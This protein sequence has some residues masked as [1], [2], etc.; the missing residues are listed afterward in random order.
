MAGW[1][2][3]AWVSLCGHEALAQGAVG[4]Y[5]LE[6]IAKIGAPVP[7][8]RSALGQD[9]IDLSTGNPGET[10]LFAKNTLVSG[11]G[12]VVYN[13]SRSLDDDPSSA[14]SAIFAISAAAGPPISQRI[15]LPAERS[16]MG[17]GL[18]FTWPTIPDYEISVFRTATGWSISEANSRRRLCG[19]I[20]PSKG[21]DAR[22]VSR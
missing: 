4:H 18:A 7:A 15:T 5:A 12:G 8:V 1:L 13:V 14:W 6:S 19:P 11:C 10:A 22:S 16:S 21:T 17:G 20:A 2:L 3:G 9:A